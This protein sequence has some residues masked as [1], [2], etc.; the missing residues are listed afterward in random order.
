MKRTASLVLLSCLAFAAAGCEPTAQAPAT[1]TAAAFQPSERFVGTWHGTTAAGGDIHIVVPASG[2][3]S[4][5]F[6]GSPVVVNSARMN[7][8]ALVLSVGRAGG[9]VVLTPTAA[10]QVQYDY[11]YQGDRASALLTRM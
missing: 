5:S 9:S 8:D 3:P 1:A 6:R 7:G 2:T 10:N 11:S 4:Y